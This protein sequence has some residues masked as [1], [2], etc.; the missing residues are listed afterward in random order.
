MEPNRLKPYRFGMVAET[1]DLYF[2][3]TQLLLARIRFSYLEYK[4]REIPLT[5]DRLRWFCL[6]TF[7]NWFTIVVFLLIASRS[8]GGL[9]YFNDF[10]G[11]LYE[12]KRPDILA[13]LCAIVF[14][15]IEYMCVRVT[16]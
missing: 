1:M 8:A 2:K 3:Y 4:N 12:L 5:I 6:V 7:C 14:L 15:S 13:L 9:D 16:L 10:L 11:Q